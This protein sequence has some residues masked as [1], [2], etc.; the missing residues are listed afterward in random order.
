[1]HGLAKV[2]YMRSRMMA[3]VLGIISVCW[4]PLLPSRPG[5]YGLL[6]AILLLACW[7]RY[8]SYPLLFVVGITW[9]V[10]YGYRVLDQQLPSSLEGQ[11]FDVKGV[12]TGLPVADGHLQRFRLRIISIRCVENPGCK[13]DVD[14]LQLSWYQTKLPVLAGQRWAMRVKLK[15]P[16]GMANPGGFDYQSWL[17]QQGV[18]AVGYVREHR[19][20][21]LQAHSAWS[22]AYWRW[23]LGRKLDQQLLDLRYGGILKALLTGDK[24][25][26][27]T[28]QWQLFAQTNTTHLMVISGLHIG[29]VASLGFG[30][31]RLLAILAFGRI[32]ADRLA[33]TLAIIAAL[34]YSAAAGFSLPTQR[35]LVMV[36]VFMVSIYLRRQLAPGHG[37]VLALL[38]CLLLDPLAP[39]GVSF[40]LS[41]SAVSVIV[42]GLCGRLG[43]GHWRQGLRVQWLAFIGLAPVL[44]LSFGQLSGLSPFA[45][46]V[47]VPIFSLLIVPFNFL[48]M[49]VSGIAPDVSRGLFGLLDRALGWQL[50]Y[51]QWLL[52]FSFMAVRPIPAVQLLDLILACVGVL[53]LLLPRG[54]PMRACGLL[55]MAPLLLS[56]APPIGHGGMVVTVLDVGQ[57][58]STVVQTRH[59]SLVFDI[60]PGFSERFST[61]TSVV[62][63]YLNYR[64][65]R[66][67]DTLVLSH[68]DN[69]HSGN[70]PLFLRSFAVDT[71]LYGEPLVGDSGGVDVRAC[72]AGHSWEWDGVSFTVLHPGEPGGGALSANNSSC[73]LRVTAGTTTLLISGDI[74]RPVELGLV[75]NLP[76]QLPADILVAPHHGSKT[77]SS[78]PFI[79]QVQ[80]QHVVF[81]SG[82]RNRF[83]HPHPDIVARYQQLNSKLYHSGE[84]GAI[85][86]SIHKGQLN[87]VQRYRSQLKRYWL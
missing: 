51:L 25:G 60:G 64:G 14:L 74:E 58:L 19:T 22:I 46:T 35:A 63:P 80:P 15:R 81:T 2:L 44:A 75:S 1:M 38:F 47:L 85:I 73:V 30:L 70:W 26:I 37:L 66:R 32:A 8:F 4:F 34:F 83:G 24:Q 41:F 13:L 72:L 17:I 55:L 42:Y 76:S 33:A 23:Q 11:Q 43:Q 57:G 6:L 49:L 68:S 84:D 18:G 40:W 53:V 52:D 79:R 69:D 12:V 36:L 78:W 45:N 16:Y 9:G 29:L 5:L 3:L 10:E 50:D 28:T 39:A 59:H 82:Y 86:F 87:S 71:L 20:N 62:I 65:I 27:T 61:A 77:S 48:A 54:V 31:G 7:R 21:Q 67:L 56:R